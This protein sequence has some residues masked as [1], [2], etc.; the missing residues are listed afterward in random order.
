MPRRKL[1]VG[2]TN[3]D[4][5]PTVPEGRSLDDAQEDI[6]DAL[7][8][9]ESINCPCCGRFVKAYAKKLSATMI[10][11]LIEFVAEYMRSRDWVK[12]TDLPAYTTTQQRGDYAALR[13]WGLLNSKEGEKALF[14]PT[15]EGYDFIRGMIE[16]P[17]HCFQFNGQVFGFSATMVDVEKVIGEKFNYAELMKAVPIPKKKI[18]KAK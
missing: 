7:E 9:G 16:V 4:L 11:Y 13:H 12:V 5:L 6:K 17:S 15:K 18:K 14:K 8:E 2:E 10:V 1:E 3:F